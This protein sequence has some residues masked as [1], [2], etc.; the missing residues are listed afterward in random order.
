MVPTST[1]S[2]E[3]ALQAA[4]QGHNIQ[5]KQALA[6]GMDSNVA[7]DNGDTLVMLAAYHG[8]LESLELLLNNGANPNQVN[9]KGQHPLTGAC[10]KG[11]LGI[12]NA[13]LAHGADCE[14]GS[15]EPSEAK[16][17]LMYAAMHNHVQ[18]VKALLDAG[19]NPQRSTANGDNALSL[20]RTMDAVY[21]IE[22]L[23]TF[24]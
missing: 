6:A 3:Q 18:V 8:N 4:R 17:P 15:T 21:S 7:N 19:A 2:P 11:Q 9:H 16:S 24:S 12:V 1:L 14:G 5:L 20:S 22:V 10:Y 13:L 23:E